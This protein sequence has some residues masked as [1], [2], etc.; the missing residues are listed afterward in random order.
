MTDTAA[1]LEKATRHV[2]MGLACV[3]RQEA[4]IQKLKA[5]GHPTYLALRLLD[6]MLVSLGHM[7][8]DREHIE[9]LHDVE[10]WLQFSNWTAFGTKTLTA[11]AATTQRTR[12]PSRA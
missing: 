7:V 8:E 5:G 3:T 2:E 12:V 10:T 9:R 1:L 6:A 4:I 11:P